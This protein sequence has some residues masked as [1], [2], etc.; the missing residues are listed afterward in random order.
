M[1][2]SLA[3]LTL[4]VLFLVST[5]TVVNGQLSFGG[6]N[7]DDDKKDDSATSSD[8]NVGGDVN[9]RLGFV[10]TSLGTYFY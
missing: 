4:F 9:T 8:E 7:D 10:A 6:D 3:L 2:T 5:K 1:R